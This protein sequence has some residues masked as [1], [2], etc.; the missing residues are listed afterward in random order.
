M[1]TPPTG[2]DSTR[3]DVDALEIPVI[4]PRPYKWE[5]QHTNW[6]TVMRFENSPDKDPRIPIKGPATWSDSTDCYRMTSGSCTP[7]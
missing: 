2:D 7:G 5:P 3:S 6:Y 4:P 1:N